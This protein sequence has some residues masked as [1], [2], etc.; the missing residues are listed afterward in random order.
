MAGATAVQP[1]NKSR[2]L[3]GSPMHVGINAEAAMIAMNHGG[4]AALM[5]EARPPHQRTIA[6]NP[7]LIHSGC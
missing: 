1:Q 3:R 4:L 7:E 2:R 5:S 6:K